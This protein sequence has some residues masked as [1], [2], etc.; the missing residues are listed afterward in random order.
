MNVRTTLNAMVLLALAACAGSGGQMNTINGSAPEDGSC[1]VNVLD[2]DSDGI[3]SSTVVRGNFAIG[4]GLGNAF[5]PKVNVAGVCNGRRVAYLPGV[6][7]GAI[8]STN[9]GVLAP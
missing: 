8:G 5:P 4:F 6:V 2:H 1:S 9:L 3:L 7:Y